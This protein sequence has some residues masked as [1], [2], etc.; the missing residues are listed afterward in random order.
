[1][2]VYNEQTRNQCFAKMQN[3]HTVWQ[4]KANWRNNITVSL[5][6]LQRRKPHPMVSTNW[7][8]GQSKLVRVQVMAK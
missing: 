5:N 4:K 3:C 1:M 8:K 6:Y 7:S 2:H